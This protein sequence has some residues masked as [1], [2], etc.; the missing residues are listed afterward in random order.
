MSI[1]GGLSPHS[2]VGEGLNELRLAYPTIQVNSYVTCLDSR[3]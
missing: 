2:I 3:P 1:Q